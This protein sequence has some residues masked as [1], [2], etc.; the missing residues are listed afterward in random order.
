M[1]CHINESIKCTVEQCTHHAGEKNFCSLD[2]ITV[3]THEA[4]P[5]VDQCTDCLSFQ[6]K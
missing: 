1:S 5:T 2:C 3:G 4:C 6:C